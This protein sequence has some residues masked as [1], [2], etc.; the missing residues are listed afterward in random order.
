[1]HV[2]DKINH[3]SELATRS[4]S[5]LLTHS[6][7]QYSSWGGYDYFW[8]HWRCATWR[9]P[10]LWHPLSLPLGLSPT[11][12]KEGTRGVACQL[13][14]SSRSNI[15]WRLR[16]SKSGAVTGSVPVM[17]LGYATRQPVLWTKKNR[18]FLGDFQ[19]LFLGWLGVFFGDI[20]YVSR[21]VDENVEL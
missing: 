18:F 17:P 16:R 4:P 12:T 14:S 6:K 13:F 8:G 20:G 11:P 2:Y 5:H 19:R 21:W 15:E 7:L 3:R 9:L 1:M 10:T